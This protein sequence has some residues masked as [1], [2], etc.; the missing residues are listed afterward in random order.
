MSAS[1]DVI[2]G[3]VTVF[4]SGETVEFCLSIEMLEVLTAAVL[5]STTISSVFCSVAAVTMRLLLTK[6][7]C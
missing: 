4:D 1:A 2:F 5:F 7:L 6:K 3:F